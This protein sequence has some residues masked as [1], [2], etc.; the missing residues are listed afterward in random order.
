[1]FR[2]AILLLTLL[3]VGCADTRVGASGGSSS[4]RIGVSTGIGF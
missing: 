4:S 1:M 3:I 2:F